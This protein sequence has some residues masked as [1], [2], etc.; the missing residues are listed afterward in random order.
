MMEKAEVSQAA[1]I[2]N[3]EINIP[4]R[5]VIIKERITGRNSRLFP[6]INKTMMGTC[7]ERRSILYVL[8]VGK[9]RYSPVY[10]TKGLI[11]RILG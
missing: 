2:R 6:S 1:G 10:T 9:I 5:E 3:Q 11:S 7:K 8:W 4:R